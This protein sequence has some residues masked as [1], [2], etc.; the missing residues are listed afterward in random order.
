MSVVTRDEYDQWRQHHVTKALLERVKLDLDQMKDLLIHVDP[1]DLK[2]LQGRC[3][4]SLNFI[5]M[6][7]EDLY[8]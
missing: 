8:E 4:V 3:K 1:E 2:D 7:Y 6:T 5:N